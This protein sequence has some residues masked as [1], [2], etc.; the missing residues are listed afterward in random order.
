MARGLGDLGSMGDVVAAPVGTIV[1]HIPG[2][3]AA[4]DGDQFA[5]VIREQQGAR[6][7]QQQAEVAPKIPSARAR[8]VAPATSRPW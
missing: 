8:G 5:T 7:G 4:V 1:V 2:V 3:Q 6:T